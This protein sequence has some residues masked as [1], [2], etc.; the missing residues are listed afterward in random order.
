LDKL[1]SY[2]IIEDGDSLTR[3]LTY[4]DI[5]NPTSITHFKYDGIFYDRALFDWEGRQLTKIDMIDDDA[6][7]VSV[8]YQY[9]DQGYRISKAITNYTYTVQEEDIYNSGIIQ[10][11]DIVPNTQNV[12]NTYDEITVY[13]SGFGYHAFTDYGDLYIEDYAFSEDLYIEVFPSG[14]YI[15]S[16]FAIW[17]VTGSYTAATSSTSTINYTL[18]NGLVLYETDGIYEILY[19]Y[20]Y[21]G[22]LISFHYD[23]NINDAADGEEYFY[24]K[25]QQGDITAIVNKL[26]V[27]EAKYRYDGWGNILSVDTPSGSTLDPSINAYTYRGYRYDYETSLY[28]CN[29]RYYNP[30]WGRWLNAD[31]VSYLDPGSTNGLNLYAY[32]GNNPI[33]RIDP[34]GT[35]WFSSVGDWF[36]DHW[37][38]VAIGAAFIVVGAL[39][40]AATAGTATPFLAAFGSALLS[41]AVQ[42]GI[43]MTVSVGVGGLMSVAQGGGF[44]DNVGDSLASGFMWGG[45]FSGGA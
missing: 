16:P 9:N 41:S 28:Y 25:N 5:G 36:E 27:V 14:I 31:D 17:K 38:E 3:Q 34:Y 2:D 23:S 42:V 26:G 6:V 11:T 33:M 15:Y 40:T 24:I 22:T 37:K 20:D 39:V 7:I 18:S 43:S 1:V 32:C 45:I 8:K 21:D 13:I 10:G 4:D 29:S 35:S 12:F 19:T 44:F 30:E